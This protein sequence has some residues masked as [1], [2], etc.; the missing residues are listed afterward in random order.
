LWYVGIGLV[1]TGEFDGVGNR[2]ESFFDACLCAGVDPEDPSI[3]RFLGS[4]VGEL[5]GQL[6]FAAAVSFPPGMSSPS[7]EA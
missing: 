6:R 1:T 4:S 2:P 7:E 3:A 5:D